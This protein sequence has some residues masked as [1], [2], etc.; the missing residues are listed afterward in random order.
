VE[1]ALA[2]VTLHQASPPT[3]RRLQELLSQLD[4]DGHDTAALRHELGQLLDAV[5]MGLPALRTDTP[6]LLPAPRVNAR[7]GQRT[8]VPE[9]PMLPGNWSLR[10]VAAAS[11]DN[12]RR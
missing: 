11:P 1:A 7:E 6:P 9:A 8:N 4:A 2:H 5:G 12:A 10:S 3:A